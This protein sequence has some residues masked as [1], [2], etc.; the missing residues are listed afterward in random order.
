MSRR[1]KTTR[2]GGRRRGQSLRTAFRLVGLLRSGRWKAADAAEEVKCNIR[3]FYRVVSA[4]EDAGIPVERHRERTDVYLR[5][6][7]DAVARALGLTMPEAPPRTVVVRDPPRCC[8][9]CGATLRRYRLC[10]ACRGRRIGA[11]RKTR[12]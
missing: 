12:R 4:V 6:R 1:T 8:K 2:R 7:R 11:G 5:V 9:G 10:A 3:T